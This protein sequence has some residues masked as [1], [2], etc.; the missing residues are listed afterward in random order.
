[1]LMLT[2]KAAELLGQLIGPIEINS[3]LPQVAERAL[4]F[5][6]EQTVSVT[7]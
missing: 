2:N 3:G 6:V 1:M 5:I 7:N 4:L